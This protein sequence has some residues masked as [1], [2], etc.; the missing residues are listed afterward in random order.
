MPEKAEN[1]LAELEQILGMTN[2]EAETLDDL[3]SNQQYAARFYALKDTY[4]SLIDLARGELHSAY[5]HLFQLVD[6]AAAPVR[7]VSDAFVEE[8]KSSSWRPNRLLDAAKAQ[9]DELVSAHSTRLEGELYVPVGGLLNIL[10]N[11]IRPPWWK[12]R[13]SFND[14]DSH[15]ETI[16]RLAT[17]IRNIIGSTISY[18][19]EGD[20]RKHA[21][22]NEQL[23]ILLIMHDRYEQVFAPEV[24]RTILHN[25][26]SCQRI[27]SY[28]FENCP[29]RIV[30]TALRLES[31]SREGALGILASA[32]TLLILWNHGRVEKRAAWAYRT[33]EPLTG[34]VVDQLFQ[35]DKAERLKQWVVRAEML[36]AHRHKGLEEQV[37]DIAERVTN[38]E[39]IISRKSE[40]K[41]NDERKGRLRMLV[42]NILELLREDTA[43]PPARWPGDAIR[44]I[45]NYCEFLWENSVDD[46]FG[47]DGTGDEYEKWQWLELRRGIIELTL[48]FRQGA[49]FREC[50]W[51]P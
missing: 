36:V 3:S 26:L 50:G 51:R 18:S 33:L 4:R 12:S 28:I 5:G 9:L 11:V 38:L 48:R 20:E 1:L 46:A 49:R 40:Q 23:S 22:I 31:P 6:G 10:K 19:H 41:N 14:L 29:A 21:Q 44:A 32:L 34:Q 39:S 37:S 30:A 15:L 25:E 27:V 42:N 17:L 2:E 7:L 43:S 24:R 45:G 16:I 35:K 47:R 13:G 8:D